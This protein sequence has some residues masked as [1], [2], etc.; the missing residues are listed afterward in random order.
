MEKLIAQL[1]LLNA[2]FYWLPLYLRK[3]AKATLLL[4]VRLRSHSLEQIRHVNVVC[5][6]FESA[7]LP[8][9]N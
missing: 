8:K 2:R 1:S 5:F 7:F 3:S 6:D 9:W 4:V